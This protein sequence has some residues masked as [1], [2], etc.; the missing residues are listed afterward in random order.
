MRIPPTFTIPWT[1]TNKLVR[2]EDVIHIVSNYPYSVSIWSWI[3][4]EMLSLPTYSE[5][6]KWSNHA[7]LQEYIDKLNTTDMVDSYSMLRAI[8]SRLTEWMEYEIGKEY[9]FSDDRENWMIRELFWFLG[10]IPNW[11]WIS[12]SYNYT[13]PISISSEEQQAIEL[14]KSLNYTVT[15]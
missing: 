6:T 15:K 12:V 11:N 13:R 4:K 3:T 10:S 7:L 1:T 9:E 14:L 5:P 8:Q 2:L